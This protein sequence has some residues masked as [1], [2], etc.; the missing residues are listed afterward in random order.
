MNLLAF[1]K[2]WKDVS[3][4]W[5]LIQPFVV[6]LLKKNVPTTITK[7]YENL[8]KYTQPAIDSL[9]KLKDKIKE[10]PSELDDYCFDQG[11]TAI[12]TFANYLL[13]EV[14]KLRS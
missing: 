2:N 4:I 3:F 1:V 6:K 11:V 8:A 12:E 10:T 13:G 14:T 7:L 5:A 9:Y